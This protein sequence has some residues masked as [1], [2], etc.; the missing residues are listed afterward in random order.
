[1][2]ISPPQSVENSIGR[3]VGWPSLYKVSFLEDSELQQF[4]NNISAALA[5]RHWSIGGGII[6]RLWRA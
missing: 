1:M 6:P 2:I 5:S 4:P 3:C